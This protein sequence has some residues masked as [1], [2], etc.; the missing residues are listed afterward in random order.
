MGPPNRNSLHS[1]EM[2]FAFVEFDARTARHFAIILARLLRVEVEIP[3]H[4]A[5]DFPEPFQTVIMYRFH[6]LFPGVGEAWRARVFPGQAA[7]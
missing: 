6:G 1:S 5:A 3:G 4:L 2:V 7:R